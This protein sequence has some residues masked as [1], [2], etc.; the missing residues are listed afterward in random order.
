MNQS[1][2]AD[3]V[4]KSRHVSD[5]TAKLHEN[6]IAHRVLAARGLTD[7][8]QLSLS[9][10][11]LLRPNQLPDIDKAVQRLI[12]A[13]DNGEKVLIV[14]DY[15]CDGATST[16]VA[17][18]GLGMLGFTRIEFF[19]PSRFTFGY[20][21]SPTIVDLATRE[22]QADLLLTVDNGV[23][24]VE[25]VALANS[26]G[27][28]VVVTDH[29][30]AP[31]TLPEAIAIVNPNLPHSQ[32]AGKNLAGV[33][34]IF[35]TLLAIRTRL[36][37]QSDPF[38]EAPL[39]QLL[40]LVAIG[41]IADVVPMDGTNRILVEQGL[42]RIRAGRCRQGVKALL[43]VAGKSVENLSTQDVG[44]GIAPRLNA[45]GRLEDMSVGVRCLLADE[46]AGAEVLARQLNE[47]NQKRRN[48]E[49][50]MR[51]SAE[52]QLAE[53]SLQAREDAFGLCFKDDSWHE[54]VIGILAG[55]L[56]EALHKPVIVFT[57]EGDTRLK[58]SARSIP[59]VH[60]RDALQ[61]IV[62][63]HPDMI[64]KFGGH[65]MAAGLTLRREQFETFSQAFNDYVK[66]CLN[67]Q[68]QA[69]ELLT[70][71]TLQ[72]DELS[73]ENAALLA[74]LMPWGQG[75]ETPLFCNSFLVKSV[76]SV[77]TGHLKLSILPVDSGT[78]ARPIDAIAFNCTLPLQ[79]GERVLAVYFLDINR[80]R[81]NVSLQLRV[82]H[83]EQAG[84]R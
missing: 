84:L 61:H 7:A 11:N 20:G 74:N 2:T 49:S 6:P 8:S 71:G 46:Q 63:E 41:T 3:V 48:I 73:L 39:A 42:R 33:G 77:G 76:R 56:K 54:G 55:R 51:V 16:A 19:I 58:G 78:T 67:A 32:F 21:L 69:R 4:I 34:V 13:R 14:G 66:Q 22:F 10:Q 64:E 26:Q 82:E 18:L 47:L 37:T 53:I 24:S 50:S 36:Q 65:A 45:A 68:H 75:F 80:W 1:S 9:L 15:D 60:I 29:H 5:T 57:A 43:Q 70:D 83:L 25:G 72:S 28:D 44:F 23:A 31:E 79:V 62:T 12:Q 35:Y 59:A 30:L 17:M 38:A 27:L 81:N 52:A 40:D